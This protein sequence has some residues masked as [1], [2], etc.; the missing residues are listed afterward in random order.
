MEL[1]G[2]KKSVLGKK[3]TLKM[4]KMKKAEEFCDYPILKTSDGRKLLPLQS[5]HRWAEIDLE[6]GDVLLSA[7]RNQYAT[8]WF[9]IECRVKGI[10]ETDKATE[11]QLKQLNDAV[12]PCLFVKK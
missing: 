7:R 10:A 8:S 11:E 12:K 6:S 3:F 4:G 9:L 1:Y 2:I 5:A